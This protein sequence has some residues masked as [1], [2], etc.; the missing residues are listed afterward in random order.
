MYIYTTSSSD[1][2]T[3]EFIDNY[4]IANNIIKQATTANEIC[5]CSSNSSFSD[6][7]SQ[8]PKQQVFPG[9]TIT[10]YIALWGIGYGTNYS[11]S[12]KLVLA[13]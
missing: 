3:I 1:Y 12:D 5:F 9:Q 2:A 11:L 8:V 13:R 7:T 10:F 4:Y 6:S